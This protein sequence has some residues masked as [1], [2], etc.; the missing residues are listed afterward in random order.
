MASPVNVMLDMVAGSHIAREVECIAEDGRLVDHC[1]AG[2]TKAE[3][4]AG[5]VL[6]RRLVT[7]SR[8]CVRARVAFHTAIAQQLLDRAGCCWARAYQAR[9]PPGI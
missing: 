3:F 4:T 9:D 8:R 2:G 5:L 1:R 6:R 7:G